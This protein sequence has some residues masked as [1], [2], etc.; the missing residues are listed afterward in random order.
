MPRRERRTGISE[1]LYIDS[2]PALEAFGPRLKAALERDPRIA[3]DTEFIRERTYAPVLEIVQVAVE[4]GNLIALLDVTA[5]KGELGPLR[6]I[7]L[8]P[9]VL[10][11]LH[12]ATQDVEILT[13][14]LGQTPAP[15]YDTQVAAAFAGYS[16]QTGY[17]AL[18]QS[19]LNVR[20][21]KD[22][23]FADWSRRPLTQAMQ[24]YAE[25]DVRYLHALHDRLSRVLQKRGRV[26]WAEEQTRR[27]LASATEEVA[28]DDLWRKVGGRSGLDG[29]QLAVLRELA[30]WRDEEAQRRDK[31]RRTVVKD[32][33]LVEVARRGYT[34]PQ[35]IL[36]LRSAPQNLGE[37][38]AGAM[39][40]A[41]KR[42]Q[43]TPR[44]EWP[45][46]DHSAPLDEQGAILVE[47]LSAAV[48]LRALEEDLPPSLLA[49]GDDLRTLAITR[50][51]PD[52]SGPLFTGW[53]GEI[54]GS[55]LHDILAGRTAIVYNP[56]KRRVR[57][58]G[59]ETDTAAR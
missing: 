49:S 38:A 33:V 45:R 21:S 29:R 40:E 24:D 42:G 54:I 51:K 13:G 14:L 25:N 53:R 10:K 59:R 15:I 37:R 18:V 3:L 12:A 4:E 20:L 30:K 1:S 17:G 31:P 50:A 41:V 5:L 43:A 2:L 46:I 7:L 23:G 27:L 16:L 19:V 52:E 9:G 56:A 32:E 47:L 39:G 58:E 57:L 36:S 34:D 11:V 26:A 8:D 44:D 35:A 22:E 55:I 6:D 28:P 48:R